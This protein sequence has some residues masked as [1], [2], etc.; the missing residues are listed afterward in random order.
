MARLRLA[1]LVK[2]RRGITSL[3][4]EAIGEVRLA[5]YKVELVD[6]LE[7]MVEAELVDSDAVIIVR[8]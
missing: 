4:V 1:E 3:D 5:E 2:E 7:A 6:G 8:S